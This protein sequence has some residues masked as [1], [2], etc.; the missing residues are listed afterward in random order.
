MEPLRILTPEEVASIHDATLEVMGRTGVLVE[1]AE[2]RA[3]LSS[4]GCAVRG[5]R[6]FFTPEVVAG[7]LE[8]AP[9]E[10]TLCGR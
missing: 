8:T 2:T 3:L 4:H 10:F 6:V 5:D 7:A 9:E 1:H